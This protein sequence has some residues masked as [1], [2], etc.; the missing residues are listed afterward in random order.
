M[1]NANVT[2]SVTNI[3]EVWYIFGADIEAPNGLFKSKEDAILIALSLLDKHEKSHV[4]VFDKHTN[5][6]V[7]NIR[8]SS[9][10]EEMKDRTRFLLIRT[11]ERNL[12]NNGWEAERVFFYLDVI[13][14]T[15]T[16]L[17]VSHE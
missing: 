11:C 10:T 13:K 6:E 16:F 7:R 9:E 1:S 14:Q 15:L 12:R 4:S 17:G 8:W 3:E 5:W 2:V